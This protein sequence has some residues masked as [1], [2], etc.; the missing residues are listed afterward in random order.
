M[1]SP[2]DEHRQSQNVVEHHKNCLAVPNQ[3]RLERRR[4]GAIGRCVPYHPEHSRCGPPSPASRRHN[5]GR[6]A[7]AASRPS[8]DRKDQ[9]ISGPESQSDA[10]A[11]DLE[12][13]K[14]GGVVKFLTLLGYAA[15]AG[16]TIRYPEVVLSTSE[17]QEYMSVGRCAECGPEV[18]SPPPTRRSSGGQK[19][20]KFPH[21]DAAN[22]RVHT[23]HPDGAAAQK[24]EIQKVTGTGASRREVASLL[25]AVTPRPHFR[26]GDAEE[27]PEGEDAPQETGAP[28]KGSRQSHSRHAATHH[29]PPIVCGT[30]TP[31]P[32]VQDGEPHGGRTFKNH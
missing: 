23:K 28:P 10:K 19:S 5:G 13:S 29:A 21:Q 3:S 26:K 27:N 20:G 18:F 14:L 15:A 17:C 6:D 22:R 1:A 16:Q 7:A 2:H 25:R 31:E 11:G 4:Y 32:R 24:S 9:P 12:V 30:T 8:P